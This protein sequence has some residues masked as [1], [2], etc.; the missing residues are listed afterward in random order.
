MANNKFA[1][2]MNKTNGDKALMNPHATNA[3]KSNTRIWQK[4]MISSLV[5]G[6]IS[7]EMPEGTG[8]ALVVIRAFFALERAKLI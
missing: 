5:Y 8:L 1:R 2:T 3:A 4:E 6:M 7:Q